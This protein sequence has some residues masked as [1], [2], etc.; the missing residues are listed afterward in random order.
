MSRDVPA[1]RLAILR[2]AFDDLMADQSFRTEMTRLLLPVYPISGPDSDQIVA[3]ML[4]VRPE[5]AAKAKK[6][7][8]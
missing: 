6:I 5:V 4:N 3:K 1:D 7:F 8:Q 2:K